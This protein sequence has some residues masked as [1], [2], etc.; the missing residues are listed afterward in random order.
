[1][2]SSDHL[3]D[4]QPPLAKRIDV[5]LT[6]CAPDRAATVMADLTMAASDALRA[7]LAEP[8][9]SGLIAATVAAAPYLTRLILADPARLERLLAAAPDDSLTRAIAKLGAD[10]GDAATAPEAM[11]ALRKF[12]A[13]LALL[14]A[15]S[16][17]AGAWPL[18][19]VTGALTTAADETI[20]SAIRFLMRRAVATGDLRPPDPAVPDKAS[21]YIVLGMGKYGARELNYSSD[22]DLIVFYDRDR[23]CLR[24]GLEPGPFFVRLTRDLVRLMQERTADGYVF[25][26]D[27]RLRPDPGATQIALSTEAALHYYEAY[28]QNWERAALIKA[29]PVAGDL[30]AGAN[31]LREL[32][33]Y[34]WRKYLDFAT[35]A[36]IHAMKRQIHA[37][38]GFGEIG[39]AGHNIKVGRGG[40]REIEFF[41]QTQQLIS[42][43]RQPDLRV[44]ATMDALDA[45]AAR[46]WITTAAA[47][48][49]QRCY[50]F[51]RT[52]EHRLQM[53]E[54]EQTQTLPRDEPTLLA[55]A[56][57]CGFPDTAAFGERLRR[58]LMAVQR[59]YAK[60]FES[61]PE[62]T[63]G[64]GN[65]VFA[66]KEDD[67]ATVETLRELGYR[68][69]QGALKVVRDWHFGRYQAMRSSRARERLTE[70]QPVLL[71]VLGT[72]PDPNVTLAAFDRF[73]KEL[74][75]GVQL[76]SLLHTNP[77]LLRLLADILGS[78]P[79]LAHI[80]S[81]RPRV[82]DAVIDPSFFG[83]DPSAEEMGRRIGH[84]LAASSDYP[85]R[86][87][88]ARIV[89]TEQAFLIGVRVLTG[90]ISAEQAGGAYARLAEAVISAM[91]DEVA[92]EMVRQHGSIVGGA[93]SVIAMGKLGGREMAANSDLDL[94]VVYD[95]PDDAPS[96][97]G[98]KPLPA[99]QYYHRFTQRLI[100]SLAAQTAEG[101]L[102]DVDMRLRP[103]GAKGP[104]A[105]HLHGFIDYQH[106]SAWTWEHLALTRA[107]V[108][109]GPPSLRGKLETG[110]TEVLRRPRSQA[111]LAADVRDMR[112][113]IAAE[114]G[115]GGVWDLKLARGGMVDI[116][117]IAQYLQLSH[118]WAHPE[119]LDQNSVAALEKLSAAGL[120][121]VDASAVLIPAARLYQSLSQ[122]MRLCLD[123]PFDPA[124]APKGLE[125]LLARAGDAPDL[126][127]LEAS[128]RETEQEVLQRF[129]EVVI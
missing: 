118:A 50:T 97:D 90:T 111:A 30:E 38:K 25:R 1:M 19:R 17:L 55:V 94:I 112:A 123:G 69:P 76:F 45:L 102:Y 106:N 83:S 119:I 62:L 27:L 8:A 14:V 36:D 16:D 22:V 114:K 20:R 85:D 58:E 107:R 35:I 99:Q 71:E 117:F 61:K 51:L 95:Y 15:L 31:L 96:S 66:G 101:R 26:T 88:R 46:G 74:P 34:I 67:P 52:V 72:T 92:A 10:I 82:L 113:R 98:A 77:G 81:R 44:A 64:K 56:C 21:G 37:F 129:T 42:G 7:L 91:H 116:E 32:G 93:V 108:L 80:L 73:L 33:P 4:N 79:R 47:A 105:S 104:V 6:D 87:D 86:L 122:I 23:I 100:A 124:R 68:D 39:V 103:S 9:V 65:M 43:G 5:R 53:L 49:L 28:G 120:L 24:D 126:V 121:A 110:I 89:G 75:T 70:L 127:R 78:A 3:A 41:V 115:A 128:L 12:K 13:E 40:I 84:E 109:T 59:H 18:A 48:E 125:Q 29:R 2:S 11:S 54:D 63:L 60:L 57:L